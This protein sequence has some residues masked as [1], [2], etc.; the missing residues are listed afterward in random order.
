MRADRQEQDLKFTRRALLMAGAG[1]L[2]F[3]GLGARL[4]SLQ[5]LETERYRLMSEDNQFNFNLLPP[6]RGRVLDRFGVAVADNRDSY[7]VLLV[8]EQAGDVAS[9]LDRLQPFLP[10]SDHERERILRTAR[11]QRSF[12][13][14][15]VAD[16]LDWHTFASINLNAPD[17]AGVT[18]D[19]GEVR[20]YAFGP[21]FAHVIGYVQPPNDED[22]ANNPRDAER[23]LRHPGFRVGKTGVEVAR[24]LDLR[25][26]A[27]ALKIEVNARGRVIRELPEQSTE[28]VSGRDVVLTLDADI[29]R[30]AHER[31]GQESASAVVMDVNTGELIAMVSTPS[32]DPNLFVGGISTAD[33]AALRENDHNP[34][35]QKSI[36]GTYPPGS[37]FKAVVAAAALEHD[38]IPPTERIN[39]TGSVRLGN[40]EFHCWRRRGHGPVNL[41]DAVKTSCDIYFYQVAERLGI[42]RLHAMATR[43]GIGEQFDIGVAGVRRGTMPN[44]AWKRAR[45]DQG[46]STGDTYNT[47]I[48]QGYVTASPLQLAVMTAR[49]AS[50]RAVSPSLYRNAMMPPAPHIGISD[51]ALASVRDG[52]RAVVEEPG[53]T[54]YSLGG[55]GLGD[56]EM[57]GKTGTAQVYS[58]TAAERESGVREQEDLPWRLRDH[59][60][61]MC[62][63]PADRPKYACVVVVEHGGGSSAATRPARDILQRVVAR[64]P[65]SRA[66]VFADVGNARSGGA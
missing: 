37:T 52:L 6:S 39:C 36:Q 34:L 41:R 4:Y 28:P 62:Y 60:L 12:H 15:T 56:I 43:F 44:P 1:G 61:F 27:G 50:G 49:V 64:D 9:A 51:A 21:S 40:R 26:Q 42:D 11:S 53:G 65:S 23:L 29:Q 54:S 3:M 58:I 19:V 30:Y 13:A 5:V 55:L 48:G 18:P 57:A 22:I 35:F 46:W 66:G 17:L 47:G 32:F 59:G 24:E 10:L 45:Y 7:R 31:L 16:D 38:V 63:A 8:P 20:S 2:A 33:Y 25:G 14:I